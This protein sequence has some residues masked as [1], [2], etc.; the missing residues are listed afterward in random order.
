MEPSDLALL[1]AETPPPERAGVYRRLGDLALFLTGIFPDHAART[2]L[3][4]I[5][6]ERL[7]RSLPRRAR[8]EVI[9]E[10]ERVDRLGAVL[11]ALGPRWYRLAARHVMVPRLGDD[12]ERVA[13]D[14]DLTR[15]FLM[16]LADRYLFARRDWLFPW[17]P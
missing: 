17:Q 6:I 9:S 15:R 16:F 12:L 11:T 7:L 5:E 10:L 2:T 1:V 8:Q 4:S 13:G 3:S 14:F